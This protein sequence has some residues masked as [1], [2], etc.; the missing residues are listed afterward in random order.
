MM[1]QNTRNTE[2]NM[3][4][5]LDLT[6]TS[7]PQ[8]IKSMSMKT[9]MEKYGGDI[10][11]AMAGSTP[12]S[13]RGAPKPRPTPKSARKPQ[14]ANPTQTMTLSDLLKQKAANEQ[15]SLTP[16][17]TPT[18][19]VSQNKT[20]NYGTPTSKSVKSPMRTPTKSPT[21]ARMPLTRTPTRAPLSRTP[22]KK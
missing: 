6:L 2:T 3:R 17:K 5:A 18:K 8:A 13:S 12:P 21:C 11:K 4:N 7:L 20:T 15:C 19:S 16:R 10:H 9:L 1:E 22:T 14:K